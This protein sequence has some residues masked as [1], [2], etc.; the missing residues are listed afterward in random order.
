MFRITAGV[1]CSVGLSFHAPLAVGKFSDCIVRHVHQEV[2]GGRLT[3]PGLLQ[4]QVAEHFNARDGY[5]HRC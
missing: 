5:G 1:L 3:T 2:I 4:H